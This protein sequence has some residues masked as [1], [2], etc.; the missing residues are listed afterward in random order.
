MLYT[1]SIR[2]FLFVKIAK[3][4]RQQL[5][6]TTHTEHLKFRL[7]RH[8]VHTYTLHTA[9]LRWRR[10]EFHSCVSLKLAS[11]SEIYR[12]RKEWLELNGKQIIT[13]QLI[14]RVLIDLFVEKQI[15]KEINASLLSTYLIFCTYL[16]S[17]YLEAS[18]RRLANKNEIICT[19]WMKISSFLSWIK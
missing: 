5:K 8:F 14:S 6:K 17:T 2:F 7:C 3:A 19:V 1:N 10:L 11:V 16:H 13:A 12:C 18:T 9:S 4:P 15:Q